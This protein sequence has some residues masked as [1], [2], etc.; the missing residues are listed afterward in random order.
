MNAITR[1]IAAAA[2]LTIA[3]TLIALGTATAGHADTAPTYHGPAASAPTHDS[4][5]WT[6]STPG[7]R[8]FPNHQNR[9]YYH[10]K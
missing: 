9:H 2:T 10:A 4:H 5:R 3:P 6:P 1:R 7:S 8:Q